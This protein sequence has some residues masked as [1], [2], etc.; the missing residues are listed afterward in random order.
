MDLQEKQAILEKAKLFF[1]NNIVENH[2]KN[3]KK[4]KHLKSFNVNPF[5]DKYLASFVFGDTSPENIAKSLI[6]PRILGTS[7]NT[8]FGMGMQ[9]FCNEVLSGYASIVSGIDIEFVDAID[10]RKK[11]CQIKSGPNTINH[12]DVTSLKNHFKDIKNLARTNK[13][14]DF[15][16]N[17]DCI[18]GIFYGEKAELSTHYTKIDEEYPVVI[19]QAFWHRLTGDE[20]F[21]FDLIDSFAQVALEMDSTEIIQNTISLLSTEIENRKP[22][23]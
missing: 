19:G 21:Y 20:N 1:K 3:T 9:N 22:L 2:I 18:I 6:Y 8:S 11:Y 5:L 4:L 23:N 17:R 14:P 12:D 13:L 16:P 10:G 7:I 15:N